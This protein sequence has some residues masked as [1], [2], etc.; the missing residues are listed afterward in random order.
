MLVL[1]IDFVYENINIA[2]VVVRRVMQVTAPFFR[3]FRPILHFKRLGACVSQE[4]AQAKTKFLE[5]LL[6]NS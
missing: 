4:L 1:Y 6:E 5:C 3:Y 2:A